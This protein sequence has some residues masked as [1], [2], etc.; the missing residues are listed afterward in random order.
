V[1][2]SRVPCSLWAALFADGER[3]VPVIYASWALG[4]FI[5]DQP[6]GHRTLVVTA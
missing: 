1:R 4:A 5:S 3:T 6:P 2:V